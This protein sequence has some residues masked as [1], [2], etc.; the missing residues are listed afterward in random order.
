MNV[1][2]EIKQIRENLEK[3]REKFNPTNNPYLNKQSNQQTQTNTSLF[4]AMEIRKGT[5][6]TKLEKSDGQINSDKISKVLTKSKKNNFR[7]TYLKDTIQFM[8]MKSILNLTLVNKEFNYF[9][10]SIY[11]FK[12]MKQINRYKSS[13]Y[14]KKEEKFLEKEKFKEK[15]KEIEKSSTKGG[16][17]GNFVGAFSNVLGN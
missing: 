2:S 12:F 11:F 7:V 16:L 15:E 14:K 10:K 9:I 3:L 13:N 17:F 5:V 8:D 4:S 6:T 1:L